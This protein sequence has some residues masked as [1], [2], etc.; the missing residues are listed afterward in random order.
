MKIGPPLHRAAAL[1]Y[2]RNNP[3]A[4]DQAVQQRAATVAQA[5]RH[6]EYSRSAAQNS[7]VAP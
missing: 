3:Q 1:T 4:D 6:R 7:S 2:T 5:N